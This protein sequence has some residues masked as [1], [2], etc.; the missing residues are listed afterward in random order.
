M[1]A[2]FVVEYNVF[3]YR[4]LS[5]PGLYLWKKAFKHSKEYFVS[6]YLTQGK[7]PIYGVFH[8]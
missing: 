7:L 8:I 2:A 6:G 3:G 4:P 1:C 5:K